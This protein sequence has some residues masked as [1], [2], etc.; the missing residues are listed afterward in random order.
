[1]FPFFRKFRCSSELKSRTKF[2]L[3]VA[4]ENIKNLNPQFR[5]ALPVTILA[6]LGAST[7]I[8]LIQPVL[9]EKPTGSERMEKHGGR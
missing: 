8:G 9:A 3:F 1:M 6:A 2:P 4:G 5:R 7:L